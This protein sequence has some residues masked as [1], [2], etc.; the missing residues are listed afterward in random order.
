MNTKEILSKLVSFPVLGGENNLSILQWIKGYIEQFDIPTQLVY[1]TDLT[2]ASIHCRVGPSVDGGVILSG[3]M[4]VVPVVGQNWDT[5]PFILTDKNDGKLYG[6]GSCDMK[7]FLACCLAILPKLTKTEL[8]TPIY[9]AFSYDEEIGCIGAPDLIKH[10]QSFYNETPQFAIIGEP[11]MMQPIIGHKGICLY[12][13]FVN[14]SAGHSS[15]ILK[16]VSAIHESAR[17]ILWLENKMKNLVASG[18]IDNRFTPPHSSMHVGQINSGIAANVIADKARFSW[19][20][21]VIPQDS[22]ETIITDFR[23][24]CNDRERLLQEIYPDFKII[25]KEQHPPVPALD[26]K[27]EQEVVQLLKKINANHQ[28]DTV[29]Y[30]AEAG[31]F[32]EAGIESIICGP[33][34]I[35]QAHRANEFVETEQLTQCVEMLEKL[36]MIN[37]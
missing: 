32:S 1:N 12:D 14:G 23:E 26:T 20:A 17:L 36:I 16:E 29:S 33:G 11:S 37:S 6:R 4:D 13:T 34:S 21:R 30:A 10:I 15:G 5:D 27:E 2:K 35:D 18:S 22:L 8:K 3:H 28:L 25:T 24:Y 9:L 7:G 19:D 31:Q